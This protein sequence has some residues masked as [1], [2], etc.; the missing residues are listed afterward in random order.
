[1]NRVPK[2]LLAKLQDRKQKNS[3]RTLDDQHDLVDF[4]S[5]DY[6]GLSQWD[7]DEK[8]GLGATGSRLISGN[9]QRTEAIEQELADFYNQEAGLFFNSGYDANLG[10]F[11]CV[12]QKGDTVLY[13]QF[14]H[15]SV[16]DGLKM[17]LAAAFSFKHN[18]LADI[19]TKIERAKGTV[20]V[21]VESVYSMDGDFCPL[22]E[23]AE[24]CE[25]HNAFLVVD[26]AHAG[27]V[28]GPAGRGMVTEL[29]LD[30][31]I[32]AKIITFGKAYGSHG[33]LILGDTVLKD[34]LINF[35][36]PLIYTTAL[37]P[38]ALERIDA[39]V[40]KSVGMETER[41]ALKQNIG[42][43]RNLVSHSNFQIGESKS[44]IQ[45][46]FVSGNQAAKQLANK[47]NQAGFAVKAILHPTVDEG[48]ERLRICIHSYN[49]TQEIED[50]AKLFKHD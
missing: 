30:N 10:F 3:F 19:K 1:M 39:V 35:S 16:R 18:N 15:A 9:Y 28:F 22:E 12:P 11:S 8:A 17:G 33:A 4:Y 5:N 29:E 46:I 34:F 27:G 32:F 2:S 43:F 14:I 42:L 50:L 45:L 40:K 23:I 38:H 48:S 25:I 24:I 21:V 49:T 20:Y 47:I 36:R 37:S 44:P 7:N 6:L 41:E 31:R 13:D 26:E